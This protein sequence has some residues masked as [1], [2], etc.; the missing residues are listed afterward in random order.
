MWSIKEDLT[1]FK[2]LEKQTNPDNNI[3]ADI[4]F[5]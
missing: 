4:M 1:Y 3:K 2:A 5:L